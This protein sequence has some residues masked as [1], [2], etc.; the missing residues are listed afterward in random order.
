MSTY[1]DD[2]LTIFCPLYNRMVSDWDCYEASLVREGELPLTD[3]PEEYRK[4]GWIELCG[5]CKYASL[6]N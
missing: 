2:E 1:E 6:E 4:P 5:N 3:I